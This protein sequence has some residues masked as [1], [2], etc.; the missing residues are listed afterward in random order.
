MWSDVSSDKVYNIHFINEMYQDELSINGANLEAVRVSNALNLE[1]FSDSYQESQQIFNKS[2]IK[3]DYLTAQYL[4]ESKGISVK[5]SSSNNVQILAQQFP[6]GITEKVYER[7][8]SNGDV[9]ELTIVRIVVS[10]NKGS[11]YKKVKS[12]NGVSYFKNG[13][14]ISQNTWD[15]ETN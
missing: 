10:G 8:D 7:K 2:D 6:Q 9:S 1:I 11:E 5:K 12:K 3:V 13:G 4:E 14:I 15:T